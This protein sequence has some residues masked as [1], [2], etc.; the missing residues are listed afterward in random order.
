MKD[1]RQTQNSLTSKVKEVGTKNGWKQKAEDTKKALQI[2]PTDTEGTK[3]QTKGK[4]RTKVENAQ[5][6]TN[7]HW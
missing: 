7:N 4:I 5:K 6:G 3:N 1:Y 2:D